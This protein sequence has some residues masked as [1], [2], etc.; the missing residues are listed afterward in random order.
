MSRHDQKDFAMNKVCTVIFLLLVTCLTLA[1]GSNR[2]L[3]SITINAAVN[4]EQIQFTA[5]GTFSASP[6]SVSP[7]PVSW[8][9]APPPSQYELTTVPFSFDCAHPESPGP[10]VAMAPAD[11]HA[12]S[13]GS[14][15]GTKMVSASASIPCP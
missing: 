7:L 4:G 1:C 15:S 10:I 9:Y 14:T 2:Q 13:S 3:R 8:S 6:T 5:T 11:A 12:P